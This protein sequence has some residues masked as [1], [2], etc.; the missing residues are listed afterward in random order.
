MPSAGFELAIPATKRS[1]TYA[2]DCADTGITG[3]IILN[4]VFQLKCNHHQVEHVNLSA[5]NAN[6]A[7]I[8]RTRNTPPIQDTQDYTGTSKHP[9]D[10]HMGGK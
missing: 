8:H 2:S 9:K 5:I 3:V 4:Y 10:I 1:Q 7:P 6:T